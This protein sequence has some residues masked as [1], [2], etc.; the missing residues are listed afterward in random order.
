MI[1]FRAASEH[2]VPRH[3]VRHPP[4]DFQNVQ[5]KVQRNSQVVG[6]VSDRCYE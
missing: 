5:A 3:R 1:D 6:S 4:T 2:T